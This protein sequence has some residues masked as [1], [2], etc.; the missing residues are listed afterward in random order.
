MI[1]CK[2]DENLVSVI[3][4]CYNS[5]K[6]IEQALISLEKQSYKYFNVIIIND[7]SNDNTDYI[8]KNYIK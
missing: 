6:N 5:E 8:I 4:P 2:E 1:K 3:I 7:G